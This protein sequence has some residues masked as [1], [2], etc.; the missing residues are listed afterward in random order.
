MNIL[1]LSNG[2]P[3]YSYFFNEIGQRFVDDGCKIYY[4]VDCK[5]SL[6]ENG[7][8]ETTH[9]HEL[10]S[11]YFANHQT[12]AEILKKYSSH[13]LNS[14]LLSDYE[15]A[16][17]Y[18]IWGS[19]N[20]AFF[21]KL[22]SALL[23]FFE[24]IFIR[25]SINVVLYENVSNS[26]AYYCWFVCQEL[27]V[28]YL[29]LSSCRLPGRFI[30]SSDPLKDNEI[31]NNTFRRLATGEI[32]PPNDAIEWCKNYI[33]KIDEITPDYMRFNNLEN[34]S[35]SAKYAKTEKIKKV[36][37]GIRHLNDDHY[38]SYQRGNPLLLSCQLFSRSLKRT[39]KLK[40][41]Y[42]LYQEP[43][44]GEKFLLYPL[45]FHP[46]SST[47]ILCG[48]YLNEFE[49]IRNIA[50]NLP[51]GLK[52]YV[53]DHI[54]AFGLPTLE[55][56]RKL[57]SLPNVRLIEPKANTKELIRKSAAVITLTSTMGY[58][59]LLLGKKV[60]LYGDVF[61]KDH[62]NV[63]I[64]TDPSKLHEI[65]GSSISEETHRVVDPQY[66]LMFVLA[67]Y[68]NTFPGTLNLMLKDKAAKN[69]VDTLYPLIKDSA[70]DN[71]TTPLWAE[72]NIKCNT[73]LLN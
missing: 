57:V 29:G 47:S 72:S 73:D 51:E 56:Y 63:V 3:N 7:I 11:D 41:L 50:F 1:I 55:F 54:S 45:H 36:I 52:L 70:F 16:T 5:T 40:T 9:P 28:R 26:F 49:T 44:P 48:T 71:L 69:Q 25:N 12:N 53:K 17:V 35:L 31:I 14:A 46:E 20:D 59:A 33:N 19:R 67:Y 43:T 8:L 32:Q 30:F 21:T 27:G 23:C 15:R 6:E 62:K 18:K 60:F 2:A 58:E 68:L 4:A 38:H 34:T 22:K 24:E 13:N 42:K 37:I 64:I 66:N 65:L 39:L 10:F 61:Y